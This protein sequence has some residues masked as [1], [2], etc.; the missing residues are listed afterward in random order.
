M[1]L[2][3]FLPL[4]LTL[5]VCLAAMAMFVK[6]QTRGHGLCEKRAMTLENDLTQPLEALLRL[7][8][9]AR[10]LRRKVT[11]LHL[12]EATAAASGNAEALPEIQEQ[13]ELTKAA[14]I[15]LDKEQRGII[16][17]ANSKILADRAQMH[18][19]LRGML[20]DISAPPLQVVAD[21]PHEIAPEYHPVTNFSARQAV[22][23]RFQMTPEQIFGRIISSLLERV[24]LNA[25][26]VF[27]E[28][29]GATLAR[30]DQTGR[31]GHQF[32]ARLWW[33][34]P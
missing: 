19:S 18:R 28:S 8:P 12:E 11:R 13:I 31:R 2:I 17:T 23:A 30:R 27:H 16:F 1:G 32:F 21:P 6:M 34:S 3:V 24:G 10:R 22:T 9:E 26:G 15:A 5:I 7:N 20:P 25:N 33:S 14:Q 4:G 29:C